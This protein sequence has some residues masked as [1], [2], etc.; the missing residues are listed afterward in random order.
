[1]SNK[2][3]E[4]YC[5][6]DKACLDTLG[7]IMEQMKLSMRAYFRIIRVARTIADLEGTPDIRPGHLLEAASFRFLDRRDRF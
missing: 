3:I 4:K 1:M 7:N 5:P 2:Q 6:L